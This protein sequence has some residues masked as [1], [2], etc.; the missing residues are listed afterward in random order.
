MRSTLASDLRHEDF[1]YA[2]A[3]VSDRCV[4][5]NYA[6]FADRPEVPLWEVPEDY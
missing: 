6:E 1:P 3:T 4:A 2:L 5:A